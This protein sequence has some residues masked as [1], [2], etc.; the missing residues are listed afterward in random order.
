MPLFPWE[1]KERMMHAFLKTER[2]QLRRFTDTDID[3]LFALHNDPDVMQ[4]LNGGRPTLPAEI[5]RECKV[6]FVGERYWVAIEKSSG[7]FL[8]W[9]A[10]HPVEGRDPDEFELG[11]RLCKSAWGK[12]YA[13][14]GSHMLIRVGFT[15]GG[16]R[17]VRAQTMA[18][19]SRSRRVME[20][21]GLTYVR[22]FHEA[23]DD[24]L[25]GTERGEVEY[26]LRKA[27]WEGP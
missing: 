11:Y 21:A 27:D 14:E 9:L 17:R 7:E 10:F 2:L 6:R 23:F 12:G 4:F 1:E 15:E 19:N 25:P 5:E 24:V 13:T 18:V 3:H 26:A 16:V 22:T 8:G 20:K